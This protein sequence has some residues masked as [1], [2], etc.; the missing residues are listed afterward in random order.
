LIANYALLLSVFGLGSAVQG[1]SDRN[2]AELSAGRIFYILDRTS[3]IDPLSTE[4][5]TLD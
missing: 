5:K 1:L 4:G 3:E 2:A